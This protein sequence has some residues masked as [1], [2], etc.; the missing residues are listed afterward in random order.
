MNA[1]ASPETGDIR[2]YQADAGLVVDGIAG[3]M[4]RA[5]ELADE[6]ASHVSELQ[7]F[8]G[9]F[10]LLI[11]CEGYRGQP[12]VPPK[13]ATSGVT[14]DYG[15]DLGRQG[16][17]DLGRLYGHLWPDLDLAAL[18]TACGRRGAAARDWLRQQAPGRWPITRKQAARILPRAAAPY[19]IAACAACPALRTAPHRV[20]TALMSAVYSAWLAPLLRAREAIV[21]ADWPA[22]AQ[23]IRTSKGHRPR[24][25]LEA[26]LI[27]GKLT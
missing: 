7:T 27:E 8:R 18:S 13:S 11:R 4:T 16:A 3:P 9:S 15:W 1:A 2:R 26:Q 21:A 14:L 10:G 6:T 5:A 19:W 23:A 17:E 24:R 25:E 20:Q 22:A 12:Y